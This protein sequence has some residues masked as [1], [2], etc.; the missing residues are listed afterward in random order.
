MAESFP[1]A[2]SE[3]TEQLS[4]TPTVAVMSTR[5][6]HRRQGEDRW[7]WRRKVRADPNKARIY[8]VLVGV[9]G[10]LLILLGVVTG[11]LPGPG[12]I[13]LVLLGLAVWASEFAWAHR[14][15]QWFKLQLHKFR[16][17]STS[18]QVLTWL[19]LVVVVGVLGYADLLIFGVP[20]WMPQTIAGWLDHLPGVHR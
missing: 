17:W 8:R 14:L 9:V 2:G 3:P 12:G 15:M 16:G 11:P 4:S 1:R 7:A 18:R 13:P 19:L 10:T 20:S 5:D 6:A